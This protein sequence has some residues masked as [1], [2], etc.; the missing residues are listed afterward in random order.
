MSDIT[1]GPF[2]LTGP[3]AHVVR[4]LTAE[5]TGDDALAEEMVAGVLP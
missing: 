2:S 3:R 5:Y 1:H 4:M